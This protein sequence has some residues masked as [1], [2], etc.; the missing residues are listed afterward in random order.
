M[1]QK[2]VILL[3]EDAV[4]VFLIGSVDELDRV[5]AAWATRGSMLNQ[6][7]GRNLKHT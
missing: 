3:V 2:R 1:G 5:D 6:D 7:L 4:E